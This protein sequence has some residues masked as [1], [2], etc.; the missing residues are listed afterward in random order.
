LTLFFSLDFTIFLLC[1][2]KICV[3]P[4]NCCFASTYQKIILFLKKN[5]QV[6]SL[7]KIEIHNISKK[8]SKILF[9]LPNF[10]PQLPNNSFSS[11]FVLKYIC[12]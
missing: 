3:S 5:Q 10:I 6:L 4:Q 8:S 2:N 1:P 11:L 12:F 7:A 9:G